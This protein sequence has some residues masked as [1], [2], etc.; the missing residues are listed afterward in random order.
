[1]SDNPAADDT[2][3]PNDGAEIAAEATEDTTATEDTGG[4]FAD[5]FA[6]P[7]DDADGEF[8]RE[9]YEALAAEYED[10]DDPDEIAWR[11]IVAR[12]EQLAQAHGLDETLWPRI[13]GETEEE[14]AA[15]I[16][17]LSEMSEPASGREQKYRQ[18]LRDA[19]TEVARLQNLTE[20]M[21]TD[22][23][24]RI[25][26]AK[27]ADPADMFIDSTTSV[28]DLLDER[29]RVDP[30]K[31]N[32]RIDEL[33]QAHPH[34]KAEPPRYRG[35]LH[36]GATVRPFDTSVGSKFAHAFAKQQD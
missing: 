12:R 23:V 16:A 11:D 31:V 7:T 27:L 29:G 19:Q 33:L 8:S 22:E 17:E 36:S 18:R 3:T 2:S 9:D 25:A 20:S 5:A 32:A 13:M 10:P 34:W 4:D 15:D 28:Y 21:L 1:M 6:P 35:P 24:L 30:D 14:I 26:A